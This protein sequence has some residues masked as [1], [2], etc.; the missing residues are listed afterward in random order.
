VTRLSKSVTLSYQVELRPHSRT[1]KSSKIQPEMTKTESPMT[2]SEN[3]QVLT[4]SSP[5]QLIKPKLHRPK[6]QWICSRK[7]PTISIKITN[8]TCQ[9][10]K[11]DNMHRAAAISPR[12]NFGS[13]TLLKTRTNRPRSRIKSDHQSPIN[14]CSNSSMKISTYTWDSQTPTA[15]RSKSRRWWYLGFKRST[16]LEMCQAYMHDTM[17]W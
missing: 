3:L 11:K 2:C 13:K 12:G 5:S 14:R 7:L 9:E 1:H 6:R 15:G 16:P 10:Y 4:A 17:G 8:A